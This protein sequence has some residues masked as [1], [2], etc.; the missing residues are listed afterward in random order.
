VSAVAID[1]RQLYRLPWSLPAGILSFVTGGDQWR[2]RRDAAR[3]FWTDGPIVARR[4]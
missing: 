3:S 4:S 1:H 2:T